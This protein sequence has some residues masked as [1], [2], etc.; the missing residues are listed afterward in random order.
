MTDKK[1]NQKKDNKIGDGGTKDTILG[2]VTIAVIIALLVWGGI[3]LFGGSDKASQSPKDTE[4][5]V[6]LPEYKVLSSIEHISTR[7]DPD[8]ESLSGDVLITD[9]QNVPPEQMLKYAKA[10]SD[11]EGLDYSMALHSTTES[12]EANASIMVPRENKESLEA[13]GGIESNQKYV[14]EDEISD[15][16]DDGYIGKF[17]DGKITYLETS[18]YYKNYQDKINSN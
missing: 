14:P 15:F 10:I 12:Y 16:I 8:K 7:N 6:T 5:E 13:L 9:G 1:P 17:E 2:L 11:K 18:N 3:A 4:Q